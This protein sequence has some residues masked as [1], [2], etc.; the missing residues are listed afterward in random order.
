M[1][2][3]P[4]LS[5]ELARQHSAELTAAAEARRLSRAARRGSRR[6]VDRESATILLPDPRPSE[7]DIRLDP[8]ETVDAELCLL[9][10]DAA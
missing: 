1:M 6:K 5:S 2:I 3:H 10:G 4:Y 9:G 8:V 7:P